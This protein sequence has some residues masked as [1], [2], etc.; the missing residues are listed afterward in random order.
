GAQPLR[1]VS[2]TAWLGELDGDA[3]GILHEGLLAEARGDLRPAI[4][5]AETVEAAKLGGKVIDREG[6]MVERAVGVTWRRTLDEVDHWLVAQ[7]EPGAAK[8][9]EIRARTDGEPK[10]ADEEV[11]RLLQPGGRDVGV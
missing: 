10:D 5:N 1:G 7:I 3:V 6:D 8:A 9:D 11:D 2:W 4:G